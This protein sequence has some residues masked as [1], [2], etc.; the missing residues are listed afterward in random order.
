MQ[1]Y[2]D[3]SQAKEAEKVWF[4]FDPLKPSNEMVGFDKQ[5]GRSVTLN[6]GDFIQLTRIEI[7]SNQHRDIMKDGTMIRVDDKALAKVASD[8][9]TIGNRAVDIAMAEWDELDDT[10]LLNKA[11]EL[12]SKSKL[13]NVRNQAIK[14]GTRLYTTIQ[15][16][17]EMIL[18]A[19]KR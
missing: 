14:K 16:L 4:Q 7:A 6:P 5:D 19:V 17:D 12:N 8:F 3:Y 18:K 10:E 1:M 11:S 9:N 15:K 13:K 2:A